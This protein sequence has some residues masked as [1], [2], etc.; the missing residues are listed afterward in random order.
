MKT[1]KVNV[2]MLV[3]TA[4]FTALTAV[5]AFIRIPTAW[6]SFTLQIFF[7][8]L[9]GILLG[10]GWGALSQLIYVLLGLAGVP[11]FTQGGGFGWHAWAE[12]WT[13]E[14]WLAVDPTWGQEI[15]DTSHLRLASGSMAAQVRISSLLGTIEIIDIKKL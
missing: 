11:I 8:F 3:L 10:P 6:V 13:G 12:I 2:Q 7:T 14:S 5:G 9:A 4:L 1:K 15:A